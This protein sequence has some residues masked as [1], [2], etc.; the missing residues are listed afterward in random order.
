MTDSINKSY[1]KRDPCPISCAL[2]VPYLSHHKYD[3]I[4]QYFNNIFVKTF[5]LN[6]FQVFN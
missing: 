1:I 3:H 6:R 2:S 4:F 5:Y